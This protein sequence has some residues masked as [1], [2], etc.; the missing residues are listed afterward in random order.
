MVLER[1]A[2]KENAVQN[3]ATTNEVANGFQ[4]KKTIFALEPRS[5]LQIG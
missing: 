1:L 3:Q 4:F 5:D 2:P